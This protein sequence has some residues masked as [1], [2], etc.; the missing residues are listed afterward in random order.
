[1]I[2]WF[3]IKWAIIIQRCTNTNKVNTI[4][5][6]LRPNE[7]IQTAEISKRIYVALAE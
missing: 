1:M 6:N 2:K 3:L 7:N 5:K 4:I